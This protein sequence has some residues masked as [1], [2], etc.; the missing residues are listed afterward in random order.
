[1][2]ALVG[3]GAW[4]KNLLLLVLSIFISK[5]GGGIVQGEE[6]SA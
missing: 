4:V 3:T 6:R 1:M 2:L 5:A